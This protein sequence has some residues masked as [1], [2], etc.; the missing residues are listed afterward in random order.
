M[1]KSE[2]PLC[3]PLSMRERLL[4][5]AAL[6]SSGG[7]SA[8][9]PQPISPEIEEVESGE[10]EVEPSGQRINPRDWMGSYA[11]DWLVADR[12]L[13][14]TAK[15]VYIALLR[16]YNIER[17]YAFPGQERLA[18]CVGKS[19]T[20]VERAIH[21]L[22]DHCFIKVKRTMTTNRYYFLWHPAMKAAKMRPPKKRRRRHS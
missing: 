13:S 8:V 15:L 12:T 5:K 2:A 10:E 9:K 6:E 3:R 22:R 21:F 19:V 11:P 4:K 14:P 17:E 7:A 1:A 16:H 18:R 20:T